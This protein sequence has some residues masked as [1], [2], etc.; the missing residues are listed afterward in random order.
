M[1]F[2]TGTITKIFTAATLVALAEEGRI[3]LDEPVGKYVKGLS[4]KLSKVTAHQLLSHTSGLREEHQQY[5]IH[6]DAMLG[7]MVRSWKEDDYCLIEPGTIY[8]HS[9]TGYILAGLLI[10]EV[11]GKPFAQV[12]HER[13][14]KPLGMERTTFRPTLV[15]TYPFTQSY[16]AFGDE[17]LKQVVPYALDAVG[18]PSGSLFSNVTDLSRFALA[19]VN[20]GKLEGQQV[21]STSL[22]SALSKPY[23][24]IPG[25]NE[26]QKGAY[27]MTID[28]YRGVRVCRNS[29]SWGG[30]TTLMWMVPEHHF[31]VIVMA[32]R[33]A[34]FFNVTAEKAME[35]LLPLQ[36]AQ[37]SA[38]RIALPMSQAEMNGYVG[39]Y[40]NEDVLELLTKEGKLW[41]KDR[42][43]MLPVTKS[44]ERYFYVGEPGSD[45]VQEFS[46]V[47]GAGGKIEYLHRAGRALKKM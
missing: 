35:L 14:F 23:V 39:T 8:S 44:G 30:F 12:M 26:D 40:K 17:K 1:L 15:M 5:G 43:A 38:Q 45:V 22:I 9:N 47:Q 16:R 41:L 25:L 27:A 28:N 29:G 13:W 33:N 32:N 20:D 4:P 46:L 11:A 3:K 31:A 36:P 34:A 24:S 18:L 37:R 19:F 2:R 7:R 6:D 42:D 21:L 10:Q